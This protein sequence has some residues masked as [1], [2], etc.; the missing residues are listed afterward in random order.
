MVG[1]KYTNRHDKIGTY[2]HW[3]LLKDLGIEV[4]SEWFKHKPESVVE[5]GKTVIMWDHSLITEKKV[6]ANRPDITIHDREANVAILIDS[7]VPHD[8][9]IVEKT[10]EKLTK[11][12][13]LEIELKKCWK[14]KS[15]KTVPIIVGA[16]GTVSTDHVQYLKILSKNLNPSIIQKTALLGTANILRSVLSMERVETSIK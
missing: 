2:V 3:V 10:A 7:S 14:L 8:T 11:Y 5:K 1:T 15:I 9:N 16:L 12:R 6:G 4:C 13:D